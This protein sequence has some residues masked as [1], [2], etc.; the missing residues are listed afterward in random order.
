MHPSLY[1]VKYIATEV[2]SSAGNERFLL[3]ALHSAEVH[4]FGR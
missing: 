2:R 3:D 4:P 1:S